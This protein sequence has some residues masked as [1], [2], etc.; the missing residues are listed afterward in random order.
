MIIW[1]DVGPKFLEEL[2]NCTDPID[3]KL[4][5]SG[6]V[7]PSKTIKLTESQFRY[8]LNDDEM[9]TEKL[10]DGIR[11]FA[12]DA[13]KLEKLLTDKFGVKNNKKTN[14]QVTKQ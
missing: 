8:Q 9:A 4:F 11:K 12:A 5:P 6:T 13:V 2:K 1:Y 7:D 3:V 10:A 14:P